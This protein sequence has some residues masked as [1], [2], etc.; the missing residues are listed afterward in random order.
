MLG[1][2]KR[3]LMKYILL[4]LLP[5][6]PVVGRCEFILGVQYLYQFFLF[7]YALSGMP[8]PISVDGGGFGVSLGHQIGWNTFE[9]FTKYGRWMSVFEY[10]STRQDLSVT[11]W[12][13]GVGFRQG[14]FTKDLYF[15]IGIS[16]HDLRAKL[17]GL[18]GPSDDPFT[19]EIFKKLDDKRIAPYVGFGLMHEYIPKTPFM[20]DF[21]FYKFSKETIYEIEFGLHYRF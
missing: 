13:A 11:D 2:I 4:T 3:N 8:T 7:D 6:Y 20:F 17:N 15:K 1:N 12:S 18:T 14:I 16:M 9:V 10:N 19:Q 21:N 5:F